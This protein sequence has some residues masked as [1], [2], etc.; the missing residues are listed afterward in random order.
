MKVTGKNLLNTCKLL[1]NVSRTEANDVL[2]SE[3]QVLC[4]LIEL[5]RETDPLSEMG[6]IV[7]GMGTLKMLSGNSKLCEPLVA[8]GVS[9]LMAAV[10]QRCTEVRNR[11]GD[12]R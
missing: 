9:G 4:P 5:L 10:L 3:E 8:A 12:R 11:H 2:F 1:F 7:Y 6:S